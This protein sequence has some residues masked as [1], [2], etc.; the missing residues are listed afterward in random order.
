MAKSP[1]SGETKTRK[2]KKQLDLDMGNLG[3]GIIE[4]SLREEAQRRYLNYALSVITARALP[5]VRDGLK[6]VQRRI[7]YAMHQDLR[8]RADTKHRKCAL[9]VGEVMGKYHPHGDSAIYD[10]L[11]RLAQSFSMRMPLVDGR[12]NFG[13]P[14]GDS[15]AAMRYTEARLTHLADELLLEFGKRT[16]PIRVNYDNTRTEPIVLPTR[17]PNLLING[18]SGIAVG[19][20]TSIPPHNPVEVIDACLA[21]IDDPK[22]SVVKVMKHIKGPDFP[23]GGELTASKQEL[24][25]VY[26]EGHGSF[27][28]RSTWKT[29]NIKRG[30]TNIIIDSIP[31]ATERSSVVS[32]IAE[33]I[34]ARKL[35]FLLDV[36]DEST[37]E[38]RIVLELKKDADPE[39]V[40]AYLHKHTPLSSN[41]QVHLTCLVPTDHPEI[42]AP[43]RLDLIG[44]LQHFL[45]FRMLVVTRRTEFELEQLNTRIHILE[46]FAKV[47]DALDEVL[48]IIRKSKGKA[49]AAEKLM[50]RFKLDEEQVEAILELKLYRLAQLEILLIQK[51][52]DEKRQAAKKLARLLKSPKERWSLIKDE[53]K[54]LRESYASKRLTRIISAEDE[55]SFDAEAFIVD[56]DATVLLSYQGRIKRQQ[57]IKDLSSTRVRDGDRVL[58]VEAGSTKASLAFFSNL[59]VCYVARIA[60][61]PATTGYGDPI[62]KLFKLKDGERIV[63]MRSFDSRVL[64]V[65]EATEG[66]EPEAPFGIAVTRLG[67]TMRF[68]LRGHRDPSTRSGRRYCR[69]KPGDEV[70]FMDVAHGDEALV[71]ATFNGRALLCEVEDTPILGGPGK[72]VMLIKLAKDDQVAGAQLLEDDRDALIAVHDSGKQFKISTGKYDIVSRA[73]KG[74]A[75]FKRGKLAGTVWPV[76]D[77]PEF[78]GEDA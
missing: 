35:P 15:A 46:G 12:G 38:T 41:V 73:G 31:Y 70:I 8:L 2:K 21:L 55:P 59:G 68:S 66:S 18:S 25:Q 40:M 76:P 19:M 28:L 9:I 45:D 39:L 27:K 29:E 5:D 60:D 37:D 44:M 11:V 7:M 20:A 57:K 53:L 62:Q 6:P 64:E 69:L 24:R 67:M 4:A 51:E 3:G 23:T 75:L 14:D 13:S 72:G 78:D 34:I 50:K 42:A 17:F 43:M 77:V 33:I 26:T 16:V 71:C 56:E 30:A 49:D 63:S 61:I 36:R 10:A 52:L 47:F 48:R 32:K 65:P 22:L 1:R 54:G 58:A 74:F